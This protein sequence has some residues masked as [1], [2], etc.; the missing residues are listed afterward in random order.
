MKK[1][2]NGSGANRV[3]RVDKKEKHK[4]IREEEMKEGRRRERERE[5]GKR[6]F[7]L[8]SKIYGNRTVGFRRSKM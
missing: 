5:K 3:V 7:S 6:G 1:K 2:K 4:E 8:L